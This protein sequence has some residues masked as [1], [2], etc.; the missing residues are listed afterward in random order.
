MIPTAVPGSAKYSGKGMYSLDSFNNINIP[1]SA[2]ITLAKLANHSLAESTWSSYRTAAKK[3]N[4]FSEQTGIPISFPLNQAT[5]LAFAGWLSN[6]GISCSTINTY[7]S[8]VRQI[9][10]TLGLEPSQLRT[11]IVNQV[12]TGK[13]NLEKIQPISKPTRIPI[14]VKVLKLIK[15]E[16]KATNFGNPD[17]LMIWLLC[18]VAFAGGFRCGE[19]LCKKE[20]E[21]DPKKDLLNRDMKLAHIRIDSKETASIQI[22]L[23]TQKSKK[24]KADQI[25]D[26]YESG[27]DICPIRAY[28]K[29]AASHKKR[30]SSLP[31]FSWES[32]KPLTVKQ[33]NKILKALVEEHL[34]PI[35]G[36]ISPHSFR[37]GLASTLATLG[38][39]EHDLM[40][41]GRWSSQAYHRYLKLPRTRRM[42]VARAIA[43]IN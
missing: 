12:L 16:L 19:L 24:V 8:G 13:E 7:I 22:K 9:H 17:K 18:T 39:E 34:A 27:G 21:F 30:E 37:S 28:K 6:S 1:E 35:N 33:F 26:I 4:Q 29:W 31:A 36:T 43:N 11:S 42:F 25:I 20:T 3:L 2:K 15:A 10:L 14:T 5:T 40:E 23:K 32:G 41:A 38:L